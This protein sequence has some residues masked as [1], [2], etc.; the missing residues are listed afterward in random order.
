VAV[1]P[2]PPEGTPTDKLRSIADQVLAETNAALARLERK[3][4]TGRPC[5][6]RTRVALDALTSSGEGVVPKKE[7]AKP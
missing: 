6:K 4:R 5:A 1:A 2:M 3:P 7:K